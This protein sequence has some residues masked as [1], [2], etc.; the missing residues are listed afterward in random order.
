MDKET[1]LALFA[2]LTE[3][4]AK[5]KGA[6]SSYITNP[7]IPLDDRWKVFV[8]APVYV[9]NHEDWEVK[10]PNYESMNGEIS[11]YDDFYRDRHTVVD[12]VDTA[13]LIKEREG[14]GEV[15]KGSYD[16]F[17][18]EVLEQNLKSFTYDC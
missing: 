9:S 11:W 13:E 17:R 10:F 5:L 7:S 1:I 18:E 14:R 3:E 15:V 4:L 6:F 8:M 2:A 16:C 12:T